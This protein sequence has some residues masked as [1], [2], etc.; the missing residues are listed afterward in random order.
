MNILFAIASV[1]LLTLALLL[2]FSRRDERRLRER[3]KGQAND[4]AVARPAAEQSLIARPVNRRSRL[5]GISGWLGLTPGLLPLRAMPMP[6]LLVLAGVTGGCATWGGS[7]AFS[8]PVAVLI[9]GAATAAT[10][11]G[12]F[13]WELGRHRQKA[14]LQIPDSLGLMVRAVRSGLPVAEAVRSVARE[15][16]DPTRAEF[17]RVIAET[18]IG[19]TLERALWGVHERTGLREYAFLSVVIGL[20]AQTGGGLAEAL[21]NV[22]DI[23]RRRVAMAAKARA[24]AGQAKASAMILV[25]LPPFAG[26][27]VSIANPGYLDKLFTDPRGNNLLVAAIAMTLMGIIVI[28][29]MIARST[30]E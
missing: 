17:Q 25:G 6:V 3:M 29:W 4:R 15:M 30:Q 8:M 19:G 26:I 13:L 21:E 28:R 27:M 1:L 7:I 14:F 23:V 12:I 16:P 10:L 22:A 18:S 24:L 2:T 20:Q 5:S 9:G 11:R